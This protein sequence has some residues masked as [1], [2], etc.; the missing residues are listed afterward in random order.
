MIPFLGVNSASQPCDILFP[1]C[2]EQFALS[3]STWAVLAGDPLPACLRQS[4]FIR[5]QAA[6][7][8]TTEIF[9]D[10]IF[11]PSKVVKGSKP[12]HIRMQGSLPRDTNECVL[13]LIARLLCHV[14]GEI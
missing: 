3:L 13:Q 7:H 11:F 9:H 6:K 10:E 1:T 5:A 4:E 12:S 8:G 2:P 14:Y